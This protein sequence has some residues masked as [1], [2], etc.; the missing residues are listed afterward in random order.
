[1]SQNDPQRGGRKDGP[2]DLDEI[3]RSL[4]DKAGRLFG[5]NRPLPGNGGGGVSATRGLGIAAGV[6][7]ALWAASGFYI[8]DERENAVITQFGRYLQTIESP[9]LHWRMPWPLMRSEIVNMTEIRS[10]DLGV[11]GG[12]DG[13]AGSAMM[14]TADQNVIEV[15]LNVQYTLTNAK[16]FLFNNKIRPDDPDARDIVNQVAESAIRE[17]VGRNNVDAVLNEGRGR[18]GEDTRVLMQQLIDRYRLGVSIA[19]VNIKDVQAPKEVQDAFRDAVKARQDRDR[20]INEGRAY[21]NDVVPRASGTAASLLQEAEG[22]QQKIVSRAEGDA[23]RFRQIAA[24][25]AKA[26]QVTRDRMYYETMQQVFKNTTKVVVDQKAGGNL[27]YLPL[28]KLIQSTAPG[29]AGQAPD[30]RSTEQL[31]PASK[32]EPVPA[33]TAP[34]RSERD[35][36]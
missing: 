18:I 28:D 8:V 15:Q 14:L 24:E 34:L 9:G 32:P 29:A 17:I 31:A 16:D 26:P 19:R 21:F 2:P 5:N 7:V 36:R 30:T 23:D 4:G 10:L 3:F 35:G 20:L 25:Y 27:L 1:M 11:S 22:Y 13:G 6:A 12:P 33:R